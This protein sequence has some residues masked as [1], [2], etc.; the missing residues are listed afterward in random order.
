MK[1]LTII[2]TA[3]LLSSCT[4]APTCGVRFPSCEELPQTAS[5][6]AIDT[7]INSQ[8][9]AY[10]ESLNTGEAVCCDEDINACA[11]EAV[12]LFCDF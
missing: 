12:D 1:L 3:I 11:E 7:C 8:G 10:Y 2:F 5:C 4:V 9:E 6:D